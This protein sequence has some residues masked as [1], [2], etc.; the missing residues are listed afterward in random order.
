MP[1]L[2]GALT[3]VLGD[4]AIRSRAAALADEIATL[5]AAS[6]IVAPIERIVTSGLGG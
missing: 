5:P 3:R 6:E 2:A 1:E 4:T